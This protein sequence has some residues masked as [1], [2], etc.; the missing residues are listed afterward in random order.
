MNKKQ[1]E[2]VIV[3]LVLTLGLLWPKAVQAQYYQPDEEVN[4]IVVDKQI[5]GL[6]ESVWKDNYPS[7][8]MAFGPNTQFE[9]RIIVKNTGN[10]NLTW[11]EVVDNL[12]PTLTYLYGRSEAKYDG[13]ARV[14][15]WK[16][17]EIKPGEEQVTVI[18][19]RT[20]SKEFLYPEMKESVN[21]VCATAESKANDCDDSRFFTNKGELKVTELPKTGSNLLMG[22]VTMSSSSLG[23][24]LYFLKKHLA[25]NS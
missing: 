10:R 11:I 4:Q 13:N 16:I 6:K 15:S 17:P 18:G 3:S 24:A 2:H 20:K 9:F 23:M 12:P 8:F 14:I 19:V 22:L 25:Q 1:V 5:K 7:D 21:K